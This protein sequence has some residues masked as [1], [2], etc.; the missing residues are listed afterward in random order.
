MDRKQLGKLAPSSRLPVWETLCFHRFVP[1]RMESRM[2]TLLSTLILS[3]SLACLAFDAADAQGGSPASPYTLSLE[4]VTAILGQDVVLTIGL[5]NDGGGEIEE[6]WVGVCA[7]WPVGLT[8][9]SMNYTTGLA[10]LNGGA[11][12]DHF[13]ANVDPVG[14]S[15]VTCGAIFSFA[16]LASIPSG[17][18]QPILEMAYQVDGNAQSNVI[19]LSFCDTLDQPPLATRVVVQGTARATEA[20]NGSV[21]YFS[22][23]PYRRGDLDANGNLDISDVV[24]LLESLFT[25]SVAPCFAAHDANADGQVDLSDPVFALNFLFGNGRELSE[26]FQQCGVDPA[27]LLEC[28]G[29]LGC[30]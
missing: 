19:T 2:N 21:T 11:G 22:S 13:V 15:G 1:L 5:T 10:A 28:H 9:L 14:G 16:G 3:V 30:P 12:P 24:A 4:N 6:I 17:F 18:S 26:P 25:P 23:T 27:S 8:P 7:G 29:Y 20:V